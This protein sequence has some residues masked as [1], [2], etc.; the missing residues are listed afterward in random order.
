M[1]PSEY[2]ALFDST[3]DHLKEELTG[4]RTNRATP[5]LIE[6]IKVSAYDGAAPMPLSQVASIT[7]PEARQLVVEPWDKSIINSIEKALKESDLGL[8]AANDGML[9]RLTMPLMTDEVKAQV[10]KVLNGKLEDARIALRQHRDKAKEEITKREKAG[11]ISEDEKFNAIEALDK[12]I[13][14]YNDTVKEMG[15]AKTNEI[16]G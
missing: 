15:D 6:N 5:A 16:K 7:V 12:K 10:I 8:S 1:S 11:D 2:T 4:L 13:K 3:M 14:E 9:I